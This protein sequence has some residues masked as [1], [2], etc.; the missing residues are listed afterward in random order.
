MKNCPVCRSSIV[1]EFDTRDKVPIFMN[2][3]YSD[4]AEARHAACGTLRMS[5]CL[6]CGFV[7]NAAFNPGI[8]VYDSSYENDQTHSPA[9]R[10]HVGERADRIAAFA[11]GGQTGIVEVGCGQ[12]GFL[13]LLAERV[14]SGG[15]L[16][17]FDPAWRGAPG[18]GPAGAHIYADYFDARTAATLPAAPNIIVSR[19]TIEHIPDPV[20]FLRSLR[21]SVDDGEDTH[22]F[23]ETPCVAW[24]LDNGQVQD[25]FYEHC[26]LFTRSSLH[27]ALAAA[28][29]EEISVTH[30]FG[31]Q[32][33]WAEART[34]P[35]DLSG[36]RQGQVR[37][38]IDEAHLRAWQSK[39]ADFVSEW[40]GIVDAAA[41][42]GPVYIW[43]AGG[44]GVTFAMLIDP[45]GERLSAA[46]DNN[47]GKQNCF[48]PLTGVPVLASTALPPAGSTIIVMNPNY[49]GEIISQTKTEGVEANF[50]ALSS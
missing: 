20:D 29:Y 6:D 22:L 47:P 41:S 25:L 1:L 37:A 12:G 31:G 18:A 39:K 17:G 26:T 44:K 32:Y 5:G 14:G 48:L 40:S 11:Q 38:E 15:E 49:L 45:S 3:R 4:R 21:E 46:I 8:I 24:I 7:W 34:G 28:G 36:H 10:A 35:V 30:V 50:L 43:G 33:L 42:K 16:A 23:L 2:R 27:Q 13:A 19:H 9:F